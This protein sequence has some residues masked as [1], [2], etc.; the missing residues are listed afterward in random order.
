MAKSSF[1]INT[2]F[3]FSEKFENNS[4]SSLYYFFKDEKGRHLALTS[5]KI[6][7]LDDSKG[8]AILFLFK[9]LN[10]K[11]F[12]IIYHLLISTFPTLYCL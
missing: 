11:V 1:K 12:K 7:F 10:K 4:L 3:I 6:N 8:A 2:F 5:P 9:T